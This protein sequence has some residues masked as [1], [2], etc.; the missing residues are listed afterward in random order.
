MKLYEI[1][2]Q[3]KELELLADEGV[4]IAD[5]MEGIEA[6]FEEKA[7]SVMSVVLN[8]GTDITTLDGEIKR[9]Q[10]RKKVMENR[11]KAIKDYLLF[12]MEASEI[13]KITCPLFTLTLAKGREIVQI[14][15]VEKI[16]TDYLNIKTS[17]VPM[18]KEILADLK[19]GKEIPG[20]L[21][22]KSKTSLRI[23]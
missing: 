12:N 22:I 21:L 4:D 10:D 1:S 11:E 18:K 9:L 19:T 8:V 20:T 13:S 14:D 17:I 23:K 6:S 16:P 3:M 15:D 2:S 5:T 7:I